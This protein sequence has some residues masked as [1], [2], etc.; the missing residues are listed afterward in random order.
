MKS[1][2]TGGAGFIGSHLVD[3][4][5]ELNHDVICIDNE[6]SQSNEE[7]RWNDGA[8][9]YKLDIC[10]YQHIAPLFYNVDYVFHMAAESRIEPSIKNPLNTNKV[11]IL[12]TTNI[13][14]AAREH[15]VQKVLYSST[16]A[17]YGRNKIPHQESMYED[18]LNPYSVSKVCGEKICRMY[19][20]LFKL[21]TV[22]FRYFNVYGPRQPKRG[23]Y[24]PVIGIFLR[25]KES[26]EPLTI[27]GDGSQRRDFIHVQDV[28]NANI[29]A[30]EHNITNDLYGTVFN[31]GSG[32][33]YSILEIANMIS[34]KHRFLEPRKGEM[35]E[36]LADISKIQQYLPW[37]PTVDLEDYIKSIL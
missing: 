28:I 32:Q 22:I 17:A 12:G 9:N 19:T 26:L 16:S 5:L 20:E 1:I 13:L 35:K 10:N 6:S 2:V 33:N 3:K 4:L 14:Q 11:N 8:D 27:V 37:Q 24:A 31:V 34:D 21:K 29:C 23:Q 15:G 7:F 30:A 36:T 18:C 25:Q